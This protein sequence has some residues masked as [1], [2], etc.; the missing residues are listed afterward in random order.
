MSIERQPRLGQ[1]SENPL[2]TQPKGVSPEVRQFS[3]LTDTEARQQLES[4]RE[5]TEQEARNLSVFSE[6]LISGK[7]LEP[8]TD[9]ETL[10]DQMW[11]DAREAFLNDV[12][13]NLKHFRRNNELETAISSAPV[14]SEERAK[15]EFTLMDN[16]MHQLKDE[17]SGFGTTPV[18]SKE[19]GYKLNCVG[20]SAVAASIF[21]EV[22]IEVECGSVSGHKIVVAKDTLGRLIYADPNGIVGEVNPQT[23]QREGGNLY[24][25][26]EENQA[27]L[28]I[29]YSRIIATTPTIGFLYSIFNNVSEPVLSSHDDESKKLWE[30]HKDDVNLQGVGED[31]TLRDKLL[32]ETITFHEELEKDKDFI[33]AEDGFM[34]GVM[35]QA[36]GKD[37]TEEETSKLTKQALVEA[38][39]CGDKEAVLRFLEG[40]AVQKL[41][42][43][44]SMQSK[45]FMEHLK[46]G[47]EGLKGKQDRLRSYFLRRITKTLHPELKK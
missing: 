19:L 24:L 43:G 42:E 3:R 18:L 4:Q 41:P 46:Q 30:L 22:G 44:F 45:T 6:R 12:V 34:K 13:P 10:R 35:E 16:Y 39:S 27:D 1:D 25:L 21:E 40:G 37:V 5:L 38:L 36:F 14:G 20:K 26:T 33:M 31:S 23:E 8:T 15:A 7:P 47:L 17:D 11:R 32:P 28:S 9:H 29:P 2:E